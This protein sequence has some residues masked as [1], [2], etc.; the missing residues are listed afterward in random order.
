MALRCIRSDATNADDLLRCADTAMYH[1]KRG[2]QTIVRYDVAYANLASQH[3]SLQTDMRRAIDRE[4][5]RLHYQP[6]VN[7]RTGQVVGVEALLRWEH[8]ERGMLRPGEFLPA[9]EQTGLIDPLTEW[10]LAQALADSAAWSAAG[11]VWTV[12][13]NVSARNLDSAGFPEVVA[14]ALRDS[15]VHPS[16]LQIEVTETAMSIDQ[17]TAKSSL[18]TLALRG[19]GVA[20]DDFGVGYASLAHL[21]TL[22]LSEVKVDRAFVRGI[23]DSDSD[24]EVVR[25]LVQLAHGLGL[26]V[27]AEGVENA[28]TARWLLAA[29][30]D[31]AQGYFFSRPLPW[32]ELTGGSARDMSYSYSNEVRA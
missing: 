20:L 15:G 30:C 16:H 23:E 29:G 24:R 1:G 6:K 17:D 11:E 27:T 26:H 3:L 25:S 9:I 2:T 13:V 10:V 21:R 31:S 28:A 19:V 22:A 8:P 5:L 32:T 4:Q 7:L 12:A 14:T 18:E